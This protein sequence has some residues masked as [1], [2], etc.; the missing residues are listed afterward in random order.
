MNEKLLKEELFKEDSEIELPKL[1]VSSKNNNIY[2]LLFILAS[3]LFSVFGVFGGFRIGFTVTIILFMALITA[4]LRKKENKFSLFGFFSAVLSVAVAFGFTVT[5]DSSVRFLS[6]LA[7]VLLMFSYFSALADDRPEI[8]DLGLLTKIFA[9]ILRMFFLMLYLSAV[10]FFKRDWEKKRS[11]FQ[12]FLGVLL[13]I[14]V[15]VVVVPL[16][17]SSDAAFSGLAEKFCENIGFTILKIVLGILFSWIVVAYCVSVEKSKLCETTESKFE[18]IDTVIVSSFLGMI[19]VCYLAYLFSQ[20]AYFFSAFSGFL[21][22]DY[23]FTAAEYARRGFF[24]MSII[25]A[26]NFA[27]IFAALLLSPKK[28][29]K[30]S[31]VSRILCTFIGVFTLII[32]ST[33]VSKMV[34]YIDRFGMT[35]LRIGTSAFMLFLSVVFISLMLRLFIPRIRVIKTAFITAGIVLAV[36]SNLNVNSIIADYNYTAYMN[37]SLKNIDVETIYELGD[38]GVPYLVKLLNVK[39]SETAETAEYYLQ[40][41]VING[42]YYELNSKNTEY[43]TVYKIKDKKYDKISEFGISRNRAYNVLDKYIKENPE[44]LIDYHES[45]SYLDYEEY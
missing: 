42:K 37:K 41:C 19:S 12:S 4:Y 33:A 5:S 16:L 38:E 44:I 35:R 22:K 3:V 7:L 43:S 14:P 9:P 27:M 25:A 36:L 13:A 31:V 24:E 29:G 40:K 30:I 8:G 11:I 26:I 2:T 10:V 18:G 20:L 17:M 1:F 23:S 21:P 15:L 39:D 6:F 28:N 32:I 45:A 34:L